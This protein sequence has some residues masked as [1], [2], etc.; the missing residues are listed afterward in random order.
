MPGR[1]QNR[2]LPASAG[3]LETELAK[4][5]TSLLKVEAVRPEDNFFR[6]GGDSFQAMWLLAMVQETFGVEVPVESIYLDPTVARLAAVVTDLLGPAPR[7]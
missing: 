5:V 7:G 1:A 6:L 4:M 3:A 2:P